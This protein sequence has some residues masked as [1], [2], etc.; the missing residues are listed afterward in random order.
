MSDDIIETMSNE[1]RDRALYMIMINEGWPQEDVASMI[2]TADRSR[3]DELLTRLMADHDR[4]Q[5][6]VEIIT[7]D[8]MRDGM[9]DFNAA[10][11]QAAMDRVQ[12]EIDEEH[13]H[14]ERVDCRDGGI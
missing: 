5:R 3:L 1:G 10:K 6:D 12:K 2:A 11:I 4:R 9:V 13:A 7:P 8:Q 14:W